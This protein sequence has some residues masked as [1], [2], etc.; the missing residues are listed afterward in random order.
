MDG[1]SITGVDHVVLRVRDVPK[2]LAFYQGVLGCKVERH[3]VDIGL[4]QLRAGTSLFD[5][6]DVNGTAGQRGGAAPGAS[7]H[8]LDH[9]A[10]CV[11]PFD[12]AVLRA[13][14]TQ[15]GVAVEGASRDNYGAGGSSP[16]LY[17]RDPEGNGIELMGPGAG[18][19]VGNVRSLE[20]IEPPLHTGAI[21]WIDIRPG[22]AF[23]PLHFDDRGYVLQLRVEPGT[24]IAPHRHTGEVHALNLSGWRE[25]IET[26]EHVGPMDYVY[27]P[28]GNHDSWR[29]IGDEPCIIHI[30]TTGRIEYLDASGQVTSHSDSHTAYALYRAWCNA[31]VLTPELTLYA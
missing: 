20:I 13:H 17:F 8:N 5:L 6:V 12:E 11:R 24:T 28:A 10:L 7:G 30:V 31:N 21:P 1:F 2:A 22:L 25:L 4:W 15:H 23:R 27:E 29:C 3:Q 14:L 19:I 26:G 18:D 9:V 16:S